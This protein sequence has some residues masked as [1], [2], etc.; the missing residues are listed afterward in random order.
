MEE[1]SEAHS[2]ENKVSQD[3]KKRQ[4]KTPSQVMALEKFYNEHKYP[5][6]EMKSEL[7]DEL[8]LTEK[9]ISG[10]F[11]HRRLKDK[12]SLGVEKCP[13]GRQERLSGITPDLGSGLGQDSCGSTKHVDYRHVDPREVES[14]RLYGH[15]FPAADLILESRIHYPERVSGMGDTS[16]ESSSSLRDGLYSQTEDPHNVE[17]SRYLAQDGLVAP[18]NS[19]GARHMGYKP[20]GY[21][22]V[23]GEIENAAITAVKRQLGRQYREDGPPLGVDFDPLPPGAFESPIRD[24]VHEPFYVGNP[25]LPHSPDVSGVKRQLSPTT[26]NEVHN[27]KLNSRDS[28]LHE[29][30]GIM[31]GINHQEKKHCKQ[32]RQKST[33]LDRDSN[34][35][36]RNPSLDMCDD[37]SYRGNRSR[38]MG[39]KHGVDGMI[40]DSFLNHHGHYGGKIANKQSL[41]GLYEDD[42]L[43]PKIVQRSEH[44]KFK[45]SISARNHCVA[46]E[47]EEK[48]ISVMV[49][50][51]DKFGG[52]GKATKDVK[53]KMKP[54]SEMMVSKRVR[55]DFPQQENVTN[56]SFSEMLPRKNHMKGSASEN[57]SSFSEDETAETSSSAE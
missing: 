12:R 11:C 19:K 4:L 45:A 40:T 35:L 36:G 25:V 31:Y 38:K 30:P 13:S 46:P 2:D 43:S 50:Q 24:P 26:R 17:T 16:S 51:E 39:S 49:T 32:I 9:Q 21:L 23:K 3:N 41:S 14:Q 28:Y 55:V 48:R 42:G 57:P 7:A 34:F 44:S 22:K 56:S 37:S 1:S 27:S 29:A 20:S 8:G 18:L 54:V 53:V 15:D 47:M 5:T 6:E 33:C 52:E 10:W